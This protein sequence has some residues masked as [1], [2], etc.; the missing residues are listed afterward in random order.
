MADNAHSMQSATVTPGQVSL[1]SQTKLT[2]SGKSQRSNVTPLQG[3]G[4]GREGGAKQTNEHG[5]LCMSYGF[6][7]K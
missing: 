6:I 1:L 4:W 7:L 2:R 5:F 3:Y